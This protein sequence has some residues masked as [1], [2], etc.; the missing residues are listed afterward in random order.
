MY[1]MYVVYGKF[2]AKGPGRPPI[3][4]G[5]GYS[6][7]LGDW[8]SRRYRSAEG[9]RREALHLDPSGRG[10]SSARLREEAA[11]LYTVRTRD[12]IEELRRQGL[13]KN[14]S[15]RESAYRRI[16]VWEQ[17][18]VLRQ[19]VWAVP[20]R[21][22][23]YPLLF[24]GRTKASTPR[25]RIR[26]LGGKYTWELMPARDSP[27]VGAARLTAA[28]LSVRMDGW[29]VRGEWWIVTDANRIVAADPRARNGE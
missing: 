25:R 12:M 7:I 26:R 24:M 2:V 27:K 4:L 10:Q 6:K 8:L 5:D 9:K 16:R 13:G 23:R 29:V 19:K 22:L 15:S 11:E 14:A 17:A 3:D 20:P 1:A 18:G 21:R 28:G